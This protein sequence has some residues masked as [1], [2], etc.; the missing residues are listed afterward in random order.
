MQPFF[1]ELAKLSAVSLDD[2]R[3]SLDRLDS[4]E[5]NKPTAGQAA[6]YAG[7]GAGAGA[8]SHVVSRGIEGKGL[9]GRSAAGAAAAGA[10]S[11]G[12]V[13]LL[14]SAMDRHSEKKTITSYLKDHEPKEAGVAVSYDL[15][16]RAQKAETGDD[17][18]AN[19]FRRDG[20]FMVPSS[21]NKHSMAG[22][23]AEL[24]ALKEAGMLGEVAGKMKNVLTTPIPGTPDLFHAGAQKAMQFGQTAVKK[25]PSKGFQAFQAARAAAGH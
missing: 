22:F 6:R 10:L 24:H 2:A 25:G 21:L 7:L 8:L 18:L 16:G 5:K 20:A 1:D 19:L 14:R 9:S 23:S 11:M 3:R 13:P 12:A 15:Q 17:F 4:L